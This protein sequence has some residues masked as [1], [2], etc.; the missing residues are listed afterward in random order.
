MVAVS[1]C[2]VLRRLGVCDFQQSDLVGLAQVASAAH[3]AEE[4]ILEVG[5]PVVHNLVVD[6]LAA[7][8]DHDLDLGADIDSGAEAVHT[9]R[10]AD[11][12]LTADRAFCHRRL[13]LAR[14]LA[15]E[16]TRV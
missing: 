4:D 2:E 8:E 7:W 10:T 9:V 14:K 15:S 5:S 11:V 16:K 3:S 1:E 13:E 12:G 6:I